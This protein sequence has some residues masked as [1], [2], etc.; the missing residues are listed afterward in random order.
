[1]EDAIEVT[2]LKTAMDVTD[3]I[4][5]AQILD[6]VKETLEMMKETSELN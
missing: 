6:Y 4:I 1:M 5:D 3:D 2:G